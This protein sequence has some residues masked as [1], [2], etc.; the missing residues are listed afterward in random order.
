M[1]LDGR[2]HKS[3]YNSEST[4]IVDQAYL[5]TGLFYCINSTRRLYNLKQTHSY[6]H[7]RS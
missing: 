5:R 7:H 6:Y 3:G 4:D 1:P 2:I